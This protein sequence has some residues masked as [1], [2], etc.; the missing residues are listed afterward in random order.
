VI[1]H[2]FHRL[3][4]KNTMKE[5]EHLGDSLRDEKNEDSV[6]ELLWKISLLD[7]EKQK[8]AA[9]LGWNLTR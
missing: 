7:Q 4:L 2:T 3:R 5:L 6:E 1:D 8:I 9:Y